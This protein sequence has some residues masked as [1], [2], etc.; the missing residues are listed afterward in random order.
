MAGLEDRAR[1]GRPRRFPPQEVAQVKAIACE[2]PREAGVALSRFS[3]AELHR[4]VT[5]RAVCEASASTIARWLAE[6]AIRPWQQRSWIFPRDRRFLE[7]AGPVLDL[8]QR[9]WKGELLHPGDFV[10]CA[11]E[12][13]QIQA[14]RRDSP[15][16]PPA[17]GR[18]QRVEHDYDRGG[19]LCYLAAWDVHR[20][21]LTAA[22]Q[23]TGIVPFGRPG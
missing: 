10:I 9:R 19:A 15:T 14:R 17:P 5:E 4:L 18:P 16:T 21:Q 8:Y 2:L 6:D 12:K 13:T 3:R 20:G 22:A 7:K 11:D 23:Q 1:S